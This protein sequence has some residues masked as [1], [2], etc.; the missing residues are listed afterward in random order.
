MKKIRTFVMAI[1][2][3]IVCII[4]LIGGFI[5]L[6]LIRDTLRG[7]IALILIACFILTLVVNV[8]M[9][10]VGCQKDNQ[11]YM[12]KQ[13][14]IIGALICNGLLAILAFVSIIV[15]PFNILSFLCLIAEFFTFLFYFLDFVGQNNYL[16][17]DDNQVDSS[18]NST[19]NKE[20]LVSIKKSNNK[21]DEKDSL[22]SKLE[23]LEIMKSQGLITDKE[24]DELKKSYIAKE[25]EK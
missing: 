19:N 14:I 20:N 24:Y 4:Y 6:S 21:K 16:K 25:L 15:S 5:S 9:I 23:K 10:Y 8:M 13:T 11:K 3:T 17:V 12:S 22:Q 1:I 2:S 7:V 18:L